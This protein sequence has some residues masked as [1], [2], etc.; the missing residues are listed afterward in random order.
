MYRLVVNAGMS[1]EEAKPLILAAWN[2]IP[3]EDR[4]KAF[5]QARAKWLTEELMK[6]DEQATQLRL[7]A[8]E[9]YEWSKQK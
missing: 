3:D 5:V 4:Q 6:L 1:V 7:E 2:S 9:I 8:F